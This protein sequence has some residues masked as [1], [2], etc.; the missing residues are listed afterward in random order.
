MKLQ[1]LFLP[2]SSN[3]DRAIISLSSSIDDYIQQFANKDIDFDNDDDA[4]LGIINL[5][6]IGQIFDTPLGALNG[7]NL[8]LQ[9]DAGIVDRLEKEDSAAGGKHSRANYE[10]MGLWYAD[11]NTIILNMDYIL[12]AQMKSTISH[13]LR[14]AL[15]DYKSGFKASTSKSY[16]TP[17]N[18]NHLK[19]DDTRYI[20]EPS[21]INARF[22]Q[23]L[24]SLVPAIRRASRLPPENVKSRLESDLKNAMLVNR[25]SE[26]FPE[27]EKS[28]HY[29]R[30]MKRAAD[31]IHKELEHNR[32]QLRN[33]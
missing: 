28:K 17:R 26:L 3:E 16:N 14:H 25:I 30:L 19:S 33:N 12:S 29:K 10:A 5:G 4:E 9:T 13:E 22:L 21:E 15:D 31:F 32:E 27:K 6:K 8:I 11:A 24:H 23:V 20:A 1:E 2:E 18:S 7:V